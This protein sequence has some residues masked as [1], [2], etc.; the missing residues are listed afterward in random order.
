MSSSAVGLSRIEGIAI[1]HLQS[2]AMMNELYRSE[3]A[4]QILQI[5][6]AR[7]TD[8][9]ELTRT[10]LYEIAAELNISIADMEAAEQQW[11]ARQGEEAERTAFIRFRQSKFQRRLAKYAIVNVFLISLNLLTAPGMLWSLYV[12]LFWGIGVALDAWKTYWVGDIEF[13]EAF[14]NWRQRQQLKRSVST[15]LNRFNRWIAS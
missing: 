12:A 7:Q 11:L 6:M 14:E 9:G 3:D 8:E 1:P 10:Q 15:V 2:V 4:Q 13:E 5:A